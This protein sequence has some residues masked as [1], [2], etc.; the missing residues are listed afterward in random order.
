MGRP[1]N[2]HKSVEVPVTASPKLVAYLDALVEEE[3]YGNSKAE[4]ARTLIWRSI[5]DLI[6]RGIIKQ[7][8][9]PAEEGRP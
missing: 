5:E 9:E 8:R 6:T 7:R 4:V 2:R 1:R 3:G